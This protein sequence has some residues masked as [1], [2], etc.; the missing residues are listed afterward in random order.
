MPNEKLYCFTCKRWIPPVWWE[1]HMAS[2]RHRN[3]VLGIPPPPF[4]RKTSQPDDDDEPD[5]LDPDAKLPGPS[6]VYGCP[7]RRMGG[8]GD[9]RMH[10]PDHERYARP[11]RPTDRAEALDPNPWANDDQNAPERPLARLAR[12][13][14][15]ARG[16]HG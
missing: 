2:I 14:R 13:R 11:G 5:A 7:R 15:E 8:T 10:C 3:C 4:T 16:D 1:R 6:V 9:G 12:E